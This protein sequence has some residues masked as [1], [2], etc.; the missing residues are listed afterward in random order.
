MSQHLDTMLKEGHDGK[1][2]DIFNLPACEAEFQCMSVDARL[3]FE[4]H[5]DDCAK[6]H[7]R[8]L[9]QHRIRTEQE[10]NNGNPS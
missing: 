4:K 7:L 3:L 10:Q 9:E 6:H 8:I 1:I 2:V 5:V